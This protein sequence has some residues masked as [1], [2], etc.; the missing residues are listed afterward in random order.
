[1]GARSKVTAKPLKGG[2]SA[3]GENLGIDRSTN[4][5]EQLEVQKEKYMKFS[6]EQREAM[7]KCRS[8][9]EVNKHLSEL[10]HKL[11]RSVTDVT[12]LLNMY[13]EFFDVVKLQTQQMSKD[14]QTGLSPAD[15]DY[16]KNLTTEHSLALMDEFK[17][18]VSDLRSV[19]TEYNMQAQLADINETEKSLDITVKLADEY[20]PKLTNTSSKLSTVKTAPPPP[21][22]AAVPAAKT[23]TNTHTSKNKSNTNANTAPVFAGFSSEGTNADD[24]EADTGNANAPF[25]GSSSAYRGRG[26]GRFGNANGARGRGGR[27]RWS[28]N[29][30]P[31]QDFSFSR[32]QS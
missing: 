5:R 24:A 1:M 25:R 21:A 3:M 2:K 15:F 31:E 10:N 20:Y 7:D 28:T 9:Q 18:S 32:P 13:V 22:V 4:V 6:T 26:R 29:A 19:Y 27:G 16:M 17:K 11:L 14:L 8:L 23:N 30:I 12:Q